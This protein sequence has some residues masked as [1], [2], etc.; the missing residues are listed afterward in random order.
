MTAELLINP[1]AHLSLHYS[2]FIIITVQLYIAIIYL[3][4]A[5]S[6]QQMKR[7]NPPHTAEYFIV[8]FFRVRL[9]DNYILHV[10]IYF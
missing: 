8:G 4:S 10:V 9:C 1:I 5:T 6:K 2:H 7:L 3:Q